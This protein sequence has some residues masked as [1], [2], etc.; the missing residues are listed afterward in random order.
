MMRDWLAWLVLAVVVLAGAALVLTLPV[1]APPGS[2]SIVETAG[3]QRETVPTLPQHS[4]AMDGEEDRIYLG[5]S[6]LQAAISAGLLPAETRSILRVDDKLRHGQFVWQEDTK[7]SG[8]LSIWVDLD[9]QLVSAFR[10]GHEI[11]TSVILYG[12]EGRDSPTGS[13]PIKA[14]YEDYH[15]RTYDAPMPYSLWLTDDGVAL[16]GSDVRWGRAT[17][18]CIGVPAEFARRLFEV[19]EKGDVVRI[20]RSSR[21]AGDPSAMA[22]AAAS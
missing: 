4:F 13:F 11:G 17:H 16:H 9:R 2:S 22:A 6:D 7:T 3:T 18:G 15:S 8:P 5:R 10:D 1:R 20:V 12:A 21:Q 14:K 19:A